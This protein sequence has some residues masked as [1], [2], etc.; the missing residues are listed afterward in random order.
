[1]H[2]LVGVALCASIMLAGTSARADTLAYNSTPSD[3]WFFGTG[4]GYAPANTAVLTTTAG[5]QLYLRMHQTTQ[6]APASDGSGVYSFALGTAPISFDWGIDA[7][8][9]GT[10]TD[11]KNGFVGG[12]PQ[13][14]TALITLT[15]IG[16]SQTFS[17]NPF[18]LGDDDEFA[19]GSA[20]NSNRLRWDPW[21][22]NPIGFDANV[23][24]TYKVNLTV[25]GLAGGTKSLDVYA[26]LGEGAVPEPASWAMMMLGLG[27]V[28]FAMRRKRVAV[29]FA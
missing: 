23:N 25:N 15:N 22:W 7:G 13:G 11:G 4:N 3:T 17:Y 18:Y 16:T 24:D 27:A 1:M 26:K 19:S 21:S 14:L 8:F 5:N 2:K 9:T 20:Q 28:G 10:G 29:S 12:I 6:L